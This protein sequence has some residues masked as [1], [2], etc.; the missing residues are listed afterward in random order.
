MDVQNEIEELAEAIFESGVVI[1]GI[2]RAH[3]LFDGDDHFHRLARALYYAGYR[4]QR[5]NLEVNK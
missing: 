2:D 3:G 4:K 1:E 5:E